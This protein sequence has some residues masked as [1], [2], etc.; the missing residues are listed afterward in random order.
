MPWRL[1]ESP[2]KAKADQIHVEPFWDPGCAKVRQGSNDDGKAVEVLTI[3]VSL[4]STFPRFWGRPASSFGR[5]RRSHGMRGRR[6]WAH[7]QFQQKLPKTRWGPQDGL[8]GG[9]GAANGCQ[10]SLNG[11]GHE[12]GIQPSRLGGSYIFRILRPKW[13]NQITK[14]RRGELNNT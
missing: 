13:L 6:A 10:R 9:L 1:S 4:L 5:Q 2:R 3:S 11:E 7:K 12:S 14:S 8:F